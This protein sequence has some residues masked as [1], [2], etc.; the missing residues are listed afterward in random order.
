MADK[1]PTSGASPGGNIQ[2]AL[3][4]LA[5]GLAVPNRDPNVLAQVQANIQAR[6]QAAQRAL[7][8]SKEAEARM[9]ETL[10]AEERRGEIQKN[11]DRIRAGY[12]E[13]EAA[14]AH[15]RGKE[16]L[17][18]ETKAGIRRDTAK[19]KASPDQYEMFQMDARLWDDMLKAAGSI[20]DVPTYLSNDFMMKAMSSGIVKDMSNLEEL[21]G[22]HLALTR[23]RQE[24]FM[25]L[26]QKFLPN[27]FTDTYRDAIAGVVNIATGQAF[28]PG[29]LIALNTIVDQNPELSEEAYDLAAKAYASSTGVTYEEALSIVMQKAAGE[30]DG[31]TPPKTEPPPEGGP[32][33]V[34]KIVGGIKERLPKGKGIE[35]GE[36]LGDVRKA[37]EGLPRESRMKVKKA[38]RKKQDWRAVLAEERRKHGGE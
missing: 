17:E 11:L 19:A 4:Q 21:S 12:R 38:W 15:E 20:E 9:Q 1:K 30:G 8:M 16:M 22:Y 2:T 13:A 10:A 27:V 7:E 31:T 34:S 14:T 33:I 5:I 24:D 25:V 36:S 3:D 29:Q 6:M 28:T 32:G 37:S 23:K 35:E 18:L 26:A